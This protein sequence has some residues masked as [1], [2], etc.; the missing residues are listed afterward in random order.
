MTEDILHHST[1]LYL[2][3]DP[4]A[5]SGVAILH[6]S[7]DDIIFAKVMHSHDGDDY[8]DKIGSILL[9]V[10]QV[11]KEHPRIV[12]AAV[13]KTILGEH[14]N[15]ASAGKLYEMS[16]AICGLLIMHGIIIR[17]YLPQQWRGAWGC[18]NSVPDAVIKRLVDARYNWNEI[19]KPGFDAYVGICLAHCV[20]SEVRMESFDHE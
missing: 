20:K 12:Y 18:Q 14:G 19:K 5:K 13:E 9:Q 3:I 15:V 16:G 6:H 8:M 1:D 10:D 7:T 11:I 17:R 2:G 4:G